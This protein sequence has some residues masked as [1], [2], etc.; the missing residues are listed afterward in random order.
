V[1]TAVGE[2]LPPAVGIAISPVPI[3]AAILMLLYVDSRSQSS[4]G[5]RIPPKRRSSVKL[6][7]ACSTYDHAR[8]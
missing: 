1:G 7:N 2:I 6:V 8:R 5:I 3:I 4:V